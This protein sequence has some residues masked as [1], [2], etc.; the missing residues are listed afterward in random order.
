MVPLLFIIGVS[1]TKNDGEDKKPSP[2]EF[3][4]KAKQF[5]D[6]IS[7][8][9]F[10]IDSFY[11]DKAIDFDQEDLVV[12]SEQNLWPYVKEYIKDDRN[13]FDSTTGILQIQQRNMKIPVNDSALI[14][15]NYKVGFT[16]NSTYIDFVDYNYVATRYKLHNIN[17]NYFTIYLDFRDKITQ[18]KAVI[19]TRFHVIP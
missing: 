12:K 14:K 4:V 10:Q 5:N 15:R 18:E 7:Q 6:F 19:Y 8:K 16:N 11:S 3:E 17:G 9:A 2:S 1:C 13:Y